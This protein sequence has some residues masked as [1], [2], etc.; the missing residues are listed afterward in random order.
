MIIANIDA[1]AFCAA[2]EAVHGGFCADAIL[3]IEAEA[4]EHGEG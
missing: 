4:A 1:R 2:C 3:S